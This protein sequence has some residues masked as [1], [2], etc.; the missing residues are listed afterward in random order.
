MSH[1]AV[2]FMHQS[3][4]MVNLPWQSTE[5]RVVNFF[6]AQLLWCLDTPVPVSL[7]EYFCRY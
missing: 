5:N 6:F 7:A 1:T 4:L 2:F 3:A